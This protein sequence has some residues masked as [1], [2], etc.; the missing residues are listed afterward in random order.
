MN[1]EG[2]LMDEPILASVITAPAP[3][4]GAVAQNEPHNIVLVEPTLRRRSELVLDVAL[5]HSV[6]HLVLGAWGCGVFRNNPETV[7]RTFA[8]FLRTDGKF[9]NVFRSV[10]FAVYDRTSGEGTFRAFAETFQADV[11]A[12]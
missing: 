11:L 2:D 1:D 10:V 7:A 4:A 3:N 12:E 6:K 5:A 8:E 9:S